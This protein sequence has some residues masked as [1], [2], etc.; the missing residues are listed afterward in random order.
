MPTSAMKLGLSYLLQPHFIHL[1][2]LA[3]NTFSHFIWDITV[4]VKGQKVYSLMSGTQHSF[5]NF[6]HFDQEMQLQQSSTGKQRLIFL[7]R[8]TLRTFRACQTL[9]VLFP[10]ATQGKVVHS[11]ELWLSA[12]S[13]IDPQDTSEPV[14]TVLLTT[15]S[16]S[17]ALFL[18]CFTR[19]PVN[20]AE[21]CCLDVNKCC[22][23]VL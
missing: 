5:A 21:V 23:K 14:C 11:G 17:S 22:S 1:H 2:S 16:L 4:E 13:A 7:L 6:S 15:D 18:P 10:R 12:E 9:T 3:S 8:L 19:L 20:D